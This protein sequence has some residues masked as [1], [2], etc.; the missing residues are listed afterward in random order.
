MK[1]G[2]N[3]DENRPADIKPPLAIGGRMLIRMNTAYASPKRRAEKESVRARQADEES[4]GAGP[5][6]F[7]ASKMVERAGRAEQEERFR[8][9]G[10]EEDRERIGRQQPQRHARPLVVEILAGQEIQVNKR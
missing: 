3:T 1:A 7:A 10:A 9:D 2:N 5:P 6:P 4:P 8:V